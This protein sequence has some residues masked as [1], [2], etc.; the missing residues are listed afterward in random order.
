MK[1]WLCAVVALVTMAGC[2]TAEPDPATHAAKLMAQAKAAAGGAQLDRAATFHSSGTRVRDGKVNG[3]YEEW[4]D[5]RTMAFTNVET[6]ASVT[7]SGGFDGKVGWRLGPDGKAQIITNP[8]QLVGTKLSGY[9]DVQGYFFPDRFPAQFTYAGAREA[10]GNRYDVVVVTP[11]GGIP[12]DLWLDPQT[13][14]L[15][16]LTAKLGPASI[17]GDI[18]QYQTIDGLQIVRTA[19]QT[20]T[21]PAGAHT[22][23]QNVAA[24]RFEPIPSERLAIPK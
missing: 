22:E 16:R 19:L 3:V 10:E 9:L 20:M 4:G 1:R 23:S 6:F 11:V 24:Y 14:L 12:I 5:Y 7:T 17:Q 2:A 18:T 15:K 21:T 13:H 8:Q